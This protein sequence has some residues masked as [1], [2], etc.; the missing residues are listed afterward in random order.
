MDV[1]WRR[2]HAVT[3]STRVGGGRPARKW[4]PSIMGKIE[5]YIFLS[6]SLVYWPACLGVFQFY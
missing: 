1:R 5:R 6:I 2:P 4:S 3:R